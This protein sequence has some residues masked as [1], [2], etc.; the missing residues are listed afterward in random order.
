MFVAMMTAPYERISPILWV[1]M[2]R[3]PKFDIKRWIVAKETGKGGYVHWQ[4][5]VQVSGSDF[6]QF[7]KWFFDRT[8]G[9]VHVE[10]SEI[11]TDYERKEGHF[12][13]SEDTARIRNQRF[14]N[15]R[16]YQERILKALEETNDREIV[17]WV[18]HQG[19]MGK[20]WLCSHLW[21]TGRAHVMNPTLN[22][23][24]MIADACS[25][26]EK[27]YRPIMVINIPRTWKW[28][29]D[30]MVTI[31]TLKDGLIS[32]PRYGN[33]TINRDIKI[34]ILTNAS[35]KLNKLSNDRWVIAS[36]ITTD[37]MDEPIEVSIDDH[38]G[39]RYYDKNGFDDFIPK[40]EIVS[41]R[42][43]L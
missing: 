25:M 6:D 23:S 34:L 29:D 18:D 33:T 20:S 1:D 3:E 7:F 14:G 38:V 10:K 37:C 11:W 35:P 15:P 17:C 12:Y 30:L 32:D 5:R 24:R 42:R 8:E 9:I 2:L 22:A 43:T 36:L 39:T 13:T 27:D 40:E 16:W 26:L 19:N 31:E 41:P 4:I 28:T 21:E